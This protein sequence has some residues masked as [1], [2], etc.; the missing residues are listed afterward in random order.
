MSARITQAAE[1]VVRTMLGQDGTPAGIVQALAGAGLLQTV[2]RP[3]EIADQ[4]E[5]VAVR[6]ELEELRAGH[7]AYVEVTGQAMETLGSYR[8]MVPRLQEQAEARDRLLQRYETQVSELIARVEGL[9]AAL[10]GR[11][12]GA[13]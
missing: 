8:R 11:P 7:A 3:A 1:S 10:S 13:E 4:A 2:E 9:Q 6:A 12:G 5:L